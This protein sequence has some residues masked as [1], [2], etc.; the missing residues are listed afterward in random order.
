MGKKGTEKNIE[1]FI[2][3]KL[4]VEVQLFFITFPTT[5]CCTP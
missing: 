1:A 5:L 4:D 3:A 2:I